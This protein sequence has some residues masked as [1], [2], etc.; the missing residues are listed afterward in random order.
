MVKKHGL[1]LMVLLF[2]T[3]C[4]ETKIIDDLALINGVAYDKSDD[5]EK[6]LQA[7]VT[8]PLI[9]RD[10]KYDRKTLTVNS[11]SSKSSRGELD[12][13]TDLQ[14][15]SGQVRIALFGE[16]LAKEGIINILDTL[17]RD[18][19]IGSRVMLGVGKGKA[20]DLLKVEIETE[21]QNA[22]YLER[23]VERLHKISNEIHFD[24]FHFNRDYFDDGIDPILPVFNTKKHSIV[25]EGI[26]VFHKDRF[27]QVLN[28]EQ[29]TILQFLKERINRGTLNLKLGETDGQLDVIMLTYIETSHKVD[30]TSTAPERKAATISIT[31]NGSVLEYTGKEDLSDPE[32]QKVMEKRIS[33]DL[34][35]RS[36]DLINLLQEHQTDSIGIGRFVRNKMT[37]KDWK[38]LDWHKEFANMDIQVKAEVKIN[39]IGKWK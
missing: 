16:E 9:T 34:T 29:S 13:L 28:S 20:G 30:I 2:L 18:P 1:T 21:G 5:D 26:G 22:T 7:T 38:A 12:Y 32:I 14:L 4:A 11:I 6:P 23:F 31:I 33:E 3:G 24:I 19:S 39:N 27:I 25:Y 15:E 35:K 10:G 17:N 8:F 36:D 37:Y